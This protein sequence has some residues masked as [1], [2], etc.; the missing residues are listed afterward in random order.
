MTARVKDRMNVPEVRAL[1]ADIVDVVREYDPAL[2]QGAAWLE[3][4]TRTT[5][6]G[7]RRTYYR[8]RSH[9]KLWTSPRGQKLSASRYVGLVGSPEQIR[10]SEMH[11]LMGKI[12]D[13]Q[14]GIKEHFR[15]ADKIRIEQNFPTGRVAVLCQGNRWEYK[16]RAR[17]GSHSL[18]T[19]KGAVQIISKW[20]AKGQY[21]TGPARPDSISFIGT[22]SGYK[23]TFALDN[24]PSQAQLNQS[25]EQFLEHGE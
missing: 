21:L 5:S 13:L 25:Y 8:W 24:L 20:Y 3:A 4:R 14:N 1:I 9:E 23:G 15:V 10:A 22:E 7:M 19:I 11:E 18:K 12:K 6:Q 17:S 16:E 2:L